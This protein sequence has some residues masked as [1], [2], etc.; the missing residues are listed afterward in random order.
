MGVINTTPDS[1]S[2]GGTLYREGRLVPELA[3]ERARAM[4]AEG[5]G[6]LDVGGESTRPGAAPVTEQEELDRVKVSYLANLNRNDRTASRRSLTHAQWWVA[7]FDPDRRNGLTEVVNGATLDVVNRVVGEVVDPDNY[8]F[9]E[10]GA[11]A[12]D[13]TT[14]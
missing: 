13:S 1:F 5:A 3:I 4:V 7:G 6:I 9:V 12:Q 2:D 10:A 14:E 11:I 8:I